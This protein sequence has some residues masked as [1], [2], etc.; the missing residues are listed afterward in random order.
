M[1]ILVATSNQGKL[2][3]IKEILNEYE[4]ISFA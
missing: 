3:E 1:K 2:K 4:I